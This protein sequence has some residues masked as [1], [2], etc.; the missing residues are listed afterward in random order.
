M[1]TSRKQT[2]VVVALFLLLVTGININL[3]AQPIPI[4]DV[5]KNEY[6]L[7]NLKSGINSENIGVRKSS[8]YFAGKYRIAEVV[9]CLVERLENEE[10]ASIR[11][12]IAYSLYEIKDS[13]GMNAVKELSLKDDDVKVKRMSSNLYEEYL[14]NNSTTAAL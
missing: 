8:I 10:E 4:T 7:D 9:N 12:L 13:D 5:T 2:A 3:F 1:K 6:A 11:L 14:N